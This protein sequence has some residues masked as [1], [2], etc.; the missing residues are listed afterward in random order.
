MVAI[1]QSASDNAADTTLTVDFGSPVTAGNTIFASVG[2]VDLASG[3]LTASLTLGGSADNWYMHRHAQRSASG[4]ITYAACWAD[5][6][7]AGG[8]TAVTISLSGATGGSDTGIIAQIW[9]V[10]G[11]P[12]AVED[13]T[14]ANSGA[15]ATWSTGA[16][17]PS[18][19]TSAASEFWWGAVSITSSF[20]GTI[21]GGSGWTNTAMLTS[22]M[23]S[24]MMAG[25]Q[26]RTTTGSP[27]YNGSLTAS[28]L[29]A[30]AEATLKAGSTP[31][32]A[33]LYASSGLRA[34][35]TI[36][37]SA[38]LTATGAIAT[39]AKL[40][41]SAPLAA[42]A[43]LA[44][45]GDIAGAVSLAA[46]AGM[47]ATSGNTAALAATAALTTTATYGG[48]APLG[49]TAALGTTPALGGPVPMS[50]AA[51]LSATGG[52]PGAASLAAT[53][54]LSAGAAQ[55]IVIALAAQSFLTSVSSLTVRTLTEVWRT[56]DKVLRRGAVVR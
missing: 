2:A 45:A 46:T 7:C 27:L 23:G 55:H 18:S 16:S 13:V 1:V 14:G 12:G 6:N 5:A 17:T 20:S 10:S 35:G 52:N 30:A 51:A 48:T 56:P 32:T 15:S 37:G 33:S 26:I 42:T 49:A 3:S 54:G 25:Y 44:P 31:G 9:E 29:W 40:G 38:H 53:S 50:A 22:P 43:S 24:A 36:G 8:A 39:T 47:S 11:L 19:T 28:Q 34:G 4:V 21:S 41:V